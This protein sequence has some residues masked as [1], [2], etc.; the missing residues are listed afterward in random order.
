MTD[1]TYDTSFSENSQPY[2][3]VLT[4]I[5]L[6]DW[7]VI[8]SDRSSTYPKNTKKLLFL[9]VC[10]VSVYSVFCYVLCVF[11]GPFVMVPINLTCPHC[12]QHF[13]FEHLFHLYYPTQCRLQPLTLVTENTCCFT[14]WKLMRWCVI[15]ILIWM[16]KES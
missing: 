10:C 2:L 12:L 3:E 8:L 1:S 11:K 16:L 14:W 5:N 4:S 9:Y 6:S 15:L 7:S 13:L